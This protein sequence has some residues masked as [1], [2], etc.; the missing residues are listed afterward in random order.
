MANPNK[1]EVEFRIGEKRFVARIGSNEASSATPHMGGKVIFDANLRDIMCLRA[2]LFVA[3]R[4]QNGVD[5]IEDAGN[6]L[7]EDPIT[8]FKAIDEAMGFFFQRWIKPEKQKA[9][10]L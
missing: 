1:G 4:G 9:A 3:V 2:L 8:C 10:I 7:D 6:L 5:T